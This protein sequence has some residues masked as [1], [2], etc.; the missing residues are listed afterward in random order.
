MERAEVVVLV[1]VVVPLGS[2]PRCSTNTTTVRMPDT[3][4]GRFDS[5]SF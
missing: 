5:S 4:G 1:A 3:A 2:I